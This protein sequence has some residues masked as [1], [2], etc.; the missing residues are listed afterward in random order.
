MELLT[1]VYSQ[2]LAQQILKNW[3]STV[4]KDSLSDQ[5]PGIIRIAEFN[6]GFKIEKDAW[7]NPIKLALLKIYFKA[8]ENTGGNLDTKIL[9]CENI[10]GLE[11]QNR[12]YALKLLWLKA[13][14]QIGYGDYWKAAD[15]FRQ[16]GAQFS[17]T[18]SRTQMYKML[19]NAFRE[20]F[21]QGRYDHLLSRG[22]EYFSFIKNQF[23]YR[24]IFAVSS[25]KT[26]NYNAAKT[27]YEWLLNHWNKHQK[28]VTW[29]KAFETL[30]AL[31]VLSME[32]DKAFDLLQQIYREKP[33]QNARLP[34]AISTLRAK[35][36][37]PII[38]VFPLFYNSSPT[39]NLVSEFF[40][41]LR[42]AH[43][44]KYIMGM[45]QMDN[46]GTIRL[47][48]G[49]KNSLRSPDL[50]MLRRILMFPAY[51]QTRDGATAYLVNRLADGYIILQIST[52]ISNE[53]KILLQQIQ[54]NKLN[55]KPWYDLYV[56]EQK[57]GLP[58]LSEI[59]TTMIGIDFSA[60]GRLQTDRYWNILKKNPYFLYL[61]LHN[62]D[63]K[64]V[65]KVH[66]NR[67]NHF[68]RSHKTIYCKRI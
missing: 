44:P 11:P 15:F 13:E 8:L 31:Y 50:N 25:N 46:A 21:K 38:D 9:V 20:D 58:P 63:G 24:Y 61:V 66:F 23:N 39:K 56:F 26:G 42:P 18:D 30:K 62:T 68:V 5:V 36:L 7:Y 28:L 37:V 52:A 19:S 67:N 49:D 27:H 2:N 40:S 41:E 17:D 45:Y 3:G 43:W 33:D 51:I 59:L 60:D 34:L 16:A 6:W 29:D 65:K 48:A 55:D 54:Q 1:F 35:Y 10:V 4:L 57:Q 32:F 22:S 47:S 64:I 14:Q 53:E 12:S